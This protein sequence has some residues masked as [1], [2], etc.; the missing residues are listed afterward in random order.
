[1][2]LTFQGGNEV[3]KFDIDRQNKKLIVTSSRTNYKPQTLTWTYLFDKG[4]E[5]EQEL[6]TDKMNDEDFK[7][8]IIQTMA[9]VGYV[10]KND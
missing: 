8:N 4:K 1:M 5:T 2:Q 10:L 6:Q 9:K 3:M 7:K